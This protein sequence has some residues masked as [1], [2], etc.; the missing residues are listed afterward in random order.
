LR[1]VQHRSFAVSWVAAPHYAR[2]VKCLSS[3]L[4]AW[5]DEKKNI[6][7]FERDKGIWTIHVEWMKLGPCDHILCIIYDTTK[8]GVVTAKRWLAP[9]AKGEFNTEN[10]RVEIDL[11]EVKEGLWM[12]KMART[13]YPW[14]KD[15]DAI[16]YEVVEVNPSTTVD[17]FRVQFPNGTYVTDYIKNRYYVMGGICNQPSEIRCWQA[18]YFNSDRINECNEDNH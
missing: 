3:L 2:P 16:S 18:P 4:R 9:D 14:D 15:M 7:I 12:P 8:G 5:L 13:V 17:T 1:L 11:Q 10:I 6:K